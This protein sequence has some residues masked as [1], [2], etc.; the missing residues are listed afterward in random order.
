MAR[1]DHR[2]RPVLSRALA[3]AGLFGAFGVGAAR[4]ET[5]LTDVKV[6]DAPHATGVRLSLEGPV[7]E[8]R[9]F[10]DGDRLVI[11]LPWVS[12]RSG[13]KAIAIDG[14]RASKLEVVARGNK[15]QILVHAG[16]SPDPF[17][18]RG[19]SPTDDGLLIIVGADSA[20][21]VVTPLALSAAAAE[22]ADDPI[23]PAD[24]SARHR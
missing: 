14:A 16:T 5:T 18:G 1:A 6:L 10:V 9:S 13:V 2:P 19:V 20:N 3:I 21:A 23:E 15:L 7:R 11:E 12:D 17:L 4:A 8:V 24:S 22:A